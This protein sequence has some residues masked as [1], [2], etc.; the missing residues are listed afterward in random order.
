MLYHL[1]L[2][3]MDLVASFICPECGAESF[4]PRDRLEGYCGACH[5]WTGDPVYMRAMK[6][7]REV[8]EQWKQLELVAVPPK[9]SY[10]NVRPNPAYL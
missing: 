6:H 1:T 2:V 8:Y 4:H 10:E 5:D 3:R 7:A 9:H